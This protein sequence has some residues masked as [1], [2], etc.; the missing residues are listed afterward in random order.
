MMEGE[1]CSDFHLQQDSQE[2]PLPG[3]G[4]GRTAETRCEEVHPS[5]GNHGSRLSRWEQ[6]RPGGNQCRSQDPTDKHQLALRPACEGH[7]QGFLG[8]GCQ[9]SSDPNA[10]MGSTIPGLDG[11]EPFDLSCSGLLLGFDLTK[12]GE[13]RKH[14]TPVFQIKQ[15]IPVIFSSIVQPSF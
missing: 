9:P 11:T 8:T 2:R 15:E 1:S 10:R 5:T 7:S 6:T 14:L 3:V 13:N 4:P 12:E